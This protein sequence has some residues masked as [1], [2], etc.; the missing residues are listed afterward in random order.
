MHRREFLSLGLRSVLGLSFLPMTG[1]AHR[2]QSRINS[3]GHASW[4]ALVTDFEREIPRF[5]TEFSVPGLSIAVVDHG[6]IAWRKGYGFADVATKVPVDSETVFEAGSMS[7]PVFAYVVLKLCEAGVI[8]LDTPL[9]QY[10]P[11]LFL[12]GDPQVELIT[13]RHILCHSSGLPNW[14]SS[15]E[16]L[17]IHFTPGSEYKYSG[18][19][20]YY[21]QT[22]ITHLKGKMNR[23]EC[24]EFEAGLEVCAT[25]IDEFMTREILA[26]FGMTSSG[27]LANETMEQKA[28][29]PHDR[30][31]RPLPKRRPSS[32]GVARYAAAGGLLTTSTDYAKF[33]IEVLDPKKPG[34]F[35]LK[36]ESIT[37]MLRPHVKVVTGPFTSSWALGWQVQENGLINHGGDNRGFHSHAIASPKTKSA[38]VVMTNGERGPELIQQLFVRPAL[39]VFFGTAEAAG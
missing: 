6:R 39:D 5:M 38:F 22:V 11:E 32:P 19:G 4:L 8:G 35:R 12:E 31:G 10:A 25:D 16:G 15:E 18:E 21:L 24:A 17:R 13:A 30:N 3:Q 29:T 26:P 7:K 20:Y 27:Y 2:D 9:S 36:K 28:A 37:E 23:N 14:R 33:M 1:C 34:R